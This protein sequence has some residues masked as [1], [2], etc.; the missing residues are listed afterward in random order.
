MGMRVLYVSCKK[1][2]GGV[3]T[4]MQ[5]TAL[6]LEARGHRV[7]V[8][9]HPDSRFTASASRGVRI[10]PRRLGMDF[11]P[12]MIVY[13]AALIKRHGIDIVVSNIQKELTIGG[14]AARLTGVPSIRRIGNEADINPRFR[15]RQEHLVDHTIAPSESVLRSVERRVGPLDRSKYTVIY[16]GCRPADHSRQDIA[17]RRR[18]WG[19]HETD[20]V[21]GYTGQIADVKGLA[22]LLEAVRDLEQ[23]CSGNVLVLTGEG[24]ARPRLEGLAASLGISERVV[25]AG[26]SPEPVRAAAAYD[27]AVL[28]SSLEGFPNSLVEYMAAGR[29]VV[30]TDVGGVGEI[31]QEGRNGL[32]VKAGD[33][34]ALV[35]AMVT[36][37]R[38][39]DLRE[40]LG[41]EAL[42]TVETRFSEE[43]MLDNLE[44][45]FESRIAG[46]R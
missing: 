41:R 14:S 15:W 17:D 2:W 18:A 28:N 29:A 3:V 23:A 30:S 32:L 12:A 35:E 33:K 27:M 4:W 7:W 44:T 43:V 37:R 20:F 9:S 13:L 34:R 19:V 8:V 22:G 11:N 42:S 46:G 25:F 5:R 31:V 40:R 1:G 16:N 45:F 38:D 24:P 39:S 21:I 26:F 36:L 6:G 10:I